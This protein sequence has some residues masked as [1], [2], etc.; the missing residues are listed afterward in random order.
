MY[1]NGQII[2]FLITNFRCVLKVVCFILGDSPAT[3]FLY[4][5]VSEH[6]VCSIFVDG[7][8]LTPPLQLEQTV[9]S[10]TSAYKIQSPGND[11]EESIQNHF[12]FHGGFLYIKC[13]GERN[14]SVRD[15]RDTNIS[16]G[17]GKDVNCFRRTATSRRHTHTH[18]HRTV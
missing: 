11:P 2:L 14:W 4:A 7:V 6:S 15:E 10:E 9:C 13:L 16:A 1:I 18:T 12:T 8:L 3:E 17:K 5:D